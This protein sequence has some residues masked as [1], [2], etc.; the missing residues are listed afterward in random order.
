MS[1]G[2]SANGPLGSALSPSRSLSCWASG[3]PS[4][5][6]RA[7]LVEARVAK[8]LRSGELLQRHVRFDLPDSTDDL[9]FREFA[10]SRGRYSPKIEGDLGQYPVTL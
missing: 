6:T 2:A 4:H 1:K 7:L 8:A 10:L 9:L 5:R 3:R